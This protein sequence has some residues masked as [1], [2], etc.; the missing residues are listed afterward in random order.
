MKTKENP[1]N[2]S[3]LCQQKTFS[4]HC[5]RFS[6]SLNCMVGIDGALS[7]TTPKSPIDIGL[8]E[9]RDLVTVNTYP[10]F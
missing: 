3:V 2:V 7:N 9:L 10:D 8:G 5:Q 6:R 4:A 1:H